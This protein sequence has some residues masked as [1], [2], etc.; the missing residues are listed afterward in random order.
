MCVFAPKL[1]VRWI[2]AFAFGLVHG[3]GFAYGL[4]ELL[5]FAGSHLVSSLLAFNVGVELRQLLVLA[6]L[7][8][9]LNFIFG[10][11]NERI[12]TIILSLV[13]GHSAW[14]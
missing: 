1:Q 6:V 2:V 10:H 4:Q 5:Q 9:V 14:H 7:I 3:F 12:T 13:I 8:P 11:V